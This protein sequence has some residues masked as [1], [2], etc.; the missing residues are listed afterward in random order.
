MASHIPDLSL[1]RGQIM[2]G[3]PH[4]RVS[5]F[6]SFD[7]D[8]ERYRVEGAVPTG[9]F[10]VKCEQIALEGYQLVWS[11]QSSLLKPP[12]ES[13]TIQTL[14][15]KPTDSLVEGLCMAWFRES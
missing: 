12:T 15:S 4:I 13:P 5:M 2:S 3:V 6:H 9:L 7:L 10:V 11:C 1:F 8:L 14:A